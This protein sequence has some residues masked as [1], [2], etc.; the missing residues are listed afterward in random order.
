M[1]RS[2]AIC[3]H[4]EAS[5]LAKVRDALDCLGREFHLPSPELIELQIALDEIVS[6]VIKYSW[7]DG[8]D[9]EFIVRITV[10]TD[11][12][13][14]EIIDDGAPFDPRRAPEP[15]R[16]RPAARV[17]H[18]GGLGIHLI[19]KLVDGFAYSRIGGR[20][21]TTLTKKFVQAQ[22]GRGEL[23]RE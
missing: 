21:H 12:V 20:N 23:N 14:L 13:V 11:D 10:R 8:V 4:N 2:V 16:R 7:S 17:S 5:E 3:L 18:P 15:P 1:T 19:R 9:H 6:N 22:S